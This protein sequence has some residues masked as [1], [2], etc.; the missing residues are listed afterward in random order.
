LEYVMNKRDKS[1]ANKGVKNIERYDLVRVQE[2]EVR[3]NDVKIGQSSVVDILSGAE[4]SCN[5]DK[6]EA[7][8]NV[9]KFLAKSIAF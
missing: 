1:E 3:T 6:T 4:G 2:V 9:D 7:Q 5:V 8:K